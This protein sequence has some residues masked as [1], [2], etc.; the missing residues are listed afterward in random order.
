MVIFLLLIFSFANE[1]IEF[2]VKS[3]YYIGLHWYEVH[4]PGDTNAY[5]YTVFYEDYFSL[6]GELR[7][8]LLKNLYL[9]LELWELRFYTYSELGKGKSFHL[10]SH[11]DC[12][13]IYLLP[14]SRKLSPLIYCGLNYEKYWGKDYQDI[15]IFHPAFEF[16]L[17]MGLIYRFKKNRKIFLE[18]QTYEKYQIYERDIIWASLL[19]SWLVETI[20]VQRI[21]LGLCFSL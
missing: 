9:R 5:N 21:N 3:T 13:F 11:L 17:G 4:W 16:R 15:R 14:I 2:G 7:Y 19:N 18:V 12:D 8:E 6:S 10:F 1:K 20:G